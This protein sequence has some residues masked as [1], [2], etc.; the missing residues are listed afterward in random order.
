MYYV[1]LQTQACLP[2]PAGLAHVA[3]V[4]TTVIVKRVLCYHIRLRYVRR[5]S[6]RQAVLSIATMA[7]AYVQDAY[8][9]NT[10]MRKPMLCASAYNR[11]MV[12][13]C[14]LST[15]CICQGDQT[16]LAHAACCCRCCRQQAAECGHHPGQNQAVLREAWSVPSRTSHQ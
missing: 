11:L 7:V 8:L 1:L 2:N 6:T 5:E 16:W 3:H 9:Q 4:T 12:S 13:F 10:K 14:W 15:C